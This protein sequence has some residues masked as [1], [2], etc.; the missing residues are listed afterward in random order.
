MIA[1]HPDRDSMY[2]MAD[3][4]NKLNIENTAMRVNMDGLRNNE[5]PVI[6]YTTKGGVQKFIAVENIIEDQVHYYD[7]ESGH[8]VESI[9]EF[10][11]KWTGIALY[12]AQDEIQAELE[13]KNTAQE[14]R[15]LQWRTLFAVMAGVT[16]VATWAFS[17]AWSSTVVCLL[18][19]CVS[20]LALSILLTMHEFGESN[21]LLHKVCHLNRLTNCNA[22]L[23]SSAAKLFGWL[24]MADIGLCYFAGSMLTLILSGVSQ[25]PGGAV[26]WL[27]ALALCAFPYT[28]FSL[29]YQTFKVKLFCPL[30]LGVISVLWTE[31]ALAVFSWKN[32]TFVPLSPVTVFSLLAGFALPVIVWAYVKPLWKEYNRVRNYEYKYLRLKSAPGVIRAMMMQEPV[33]DMGFTADEINLGITDAPL[34]LTIVVSMHCKPCID[35]WHLLNKWLATYHGYLQATIR[36]HEYNL[37]GS[38]ISELIDGLTGIYLHSGNAAF[39]DALTDWYNTK[40]F[41]AWKAKYYQETPI[42]PHQSSIKIA[43]WVQANSI[44]HVPTLFVDNRLFP[45]ELTDL[46]YLLK[47]L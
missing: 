25:N 37:Q 12:A 5:F 45:F 39:C 33:R 8:A 19:L 13:R 42:T 2:A 14:K 30:C 32:L 15:L 9:N 24:S 1:S 6:V 17:V 34:H 21:R 20:G 26:P 40:A 28:I 22:V 7:A 16:S 23:Q 18:A 4:L 29:W 38:E 43:Q 10:A 31:T 27:L 47:E 41:Q 35:A 44:A 46:E 36:F 11:D 3:A